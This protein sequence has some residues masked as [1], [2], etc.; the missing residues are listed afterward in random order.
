MSELNGRWRATYT[1]GPWV[2]LS[3][4][5]LLVMM[6]PAA[7]KHS[8]LLHDIWS[9]VVTASSVLDLTQTLSAVRLDALPNFGVFF[10]A[11]G[12]MRSLLRGSVKVRGAATGGILAT[13]EGVQTWAEIGLGEVNHFHVDLAPTTGDVLQLPLV[14]GAVTASAIQLDCSDEARLVFPESEVPLVPVNRE[15]APHGV[16]HISAPLPRIVPVLR[17]SGPQAFPPPAAPLPEPTA[18][19][20]D[21]TPQIGLPPPPER[22][23][24][25]AALSAEA[26]EAPDADPA[27]A[28]EYVETIPA[29]AHTERVSED[30]PRTRARAQR[31]FAE[32]AAAESEMQSDHAP[33]RAASQ[34]D[35]V[36][37]TASPDVPPAPSGDT[38][39]EEPH[40]EPVRSEPILL[41]EPEE[42]DGVAFDSQHR[43]EARAADRGPAASVG[44]FARSD[45]VEQPTELMSPISAG[46][47]DDDSHT[48]VGPPAA[49]FRVPPPP[50]VVGVPATSPAGPFRGPVG[51]ASNRTRQVNAGAPYGSP[52]GGSAP[53][54]RQFNQQSHLRPVAP[55]NV[56]PASPQSAMLRA[57]DVD[58]VPGNDA[59]LDWARSAPVPSPSG[60]SPVEPALAQGRWQPVGSSPQPQ[61][62]GQALFNPAQ[63][64][65]ALAQPGGALISSIPS[66]G[67]QA[68]PLG[69]P[70][71][72]S[73]S[74]HDGETIFATGIAA[75][76]KVGATTT[77]APD[78]LVLAAMCNRQHPNPPDAANC[79]RCGGPVDTTSPQ[80]VN[81]PVLAVLK[82]STGQVSELDG[83][84]LVGR[85]PSAQ[86]TDHDPALMTVPSPSQDISRT[87]LR[88]SAVQWEIVVTDLHSTNGTVLIRRGE[89]PVRM[90]PGEPVVVGIGAVVDLGDGVTVLIDQPH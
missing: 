41:D 61:S 58:A 50:N 6:P 73:A 75:T 15:D 9:S 35:A 11:D 72:P 24:P 74:E 76:H 43:E 14:T 38:L 90:L 44:G 88:F 69:L 77:P 37:E 59:G 63:P 34:I 5:T 65:N 60:P 49:V 36:D 2:I 66:F 21:S 83:V 68:Q 57:P 40:V 54:A 7:P 3:G 79:S 18:V 89:A 47:I 29:R 67:S 52:H 17:A 64:T 39:P 42:G 31:G 86:P 30:D 8:Q 85:A 70:A 33:A 26:P 82:A 87:H 4:P 10:W 84:V 19:A 27:P 45:D 71:Q 23:I 25:S 28:P 51:V 53:H 16:S 62:P 48:L 56:A 55:M 22:P 32:P 13:G 80:L 46:G 81:L 1:P 12:Q 20:G 78:D